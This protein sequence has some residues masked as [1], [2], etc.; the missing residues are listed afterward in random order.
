[1]ERCLLFFGDGLVN[2]RRFGGP[3][4]RGQPNGIPSG[5]VLR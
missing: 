4:F 5:I 3:P 1:M 2:E